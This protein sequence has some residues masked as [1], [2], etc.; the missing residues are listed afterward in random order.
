MRLSI[1][2]LQVTTAIAT[3]CD[4]PHQAKAKVQRRGAPTM[5]P[6]H[7]P[8]CTP[9]QHFTFTPSVTP[10]AADHSVVARILARPKELGD[11]GNRALWEARERRSK[12]RGSNAEGCITTRGGEDARRTR[13][14]YRQGKQNERGMG[15]ERGASPEVLQRC[16]P[17]SSVS[18]HSSTTW[19]P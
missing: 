10:S 1:L 18:L 19:M 3:W 11:L 17:T 14:E 16:A 8:W 9:T 15:D 7:S 13:R 5:P 6:T 2:H 4:V 12:R